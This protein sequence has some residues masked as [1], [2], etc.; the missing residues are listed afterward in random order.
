LI[1]GISGEKLVKRA[2][3]MTEGEFCVSDLV[4]CTVLLLAPCS[5]LRLQRLSR[6]TVAAGPISGAAFLDGASNPSGAY[7]SGQWL[8]CLI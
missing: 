4:D 7:N 5:T 3:S 8:S 6:C 1:R 2:G